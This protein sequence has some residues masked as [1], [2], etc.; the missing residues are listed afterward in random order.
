MKRSTHALIRCAPWAILS[1]AAT[2]PAIADTVVLHPAT[3]AGT[4]SLPGWTVT[5]SSVS[6]TSNDGFD[7]SGSFQGST[8]ALTVEGD[9][10]YRRRVNASVTNGGV[11]S[12]LRVD[13][14]NYIHLAQGDTTTDDLTYAVADITGTISVAGATITSYSLTASASEGMESYWAYAS[15]GGSSSFAFPMIQDSVVQVSGNVSA[16]T[17]GGEKLTL[18]LS[19]Q[20]VN[21]GAAG[22]TLQWDIAPSS[23]GSLTGTFNISGP[24]IVSSHHA[25][26]YLGAISK[27]ANYLPPNGSYTLTG[28]L[29]GTYNTYGFTYFNAPYGWL[30]HPSQ[31]IAV[32]A[33]GIAVR[34]YSTSLALADGEIDV[35]GFY[36]NESVTYAYISAWGLGGSSAWD[37]VDLPSGQYKL[38][39]SA[40]SWIS[41][42]YQVDVVKQTPYTNATFQI[43][44]GTGGWSLAGGDELDLG[45]QDIM[46][47]ETMI[48]FDV[49][50][51][52]GSGTETPI[53]QPR[54]SG[55]APGRSFSA[56]GPTIEDARPVVRIVAS[57]G[58]YSA[59]AYG[60][61]NGSNVNF[62]DFTFTV[63]SPVF[64][65]SGTDVFVQPAPNVTLTFD[66]VNPPGGYTSVTSSPIGPQPPEGFQL[67]HPLAPMYYD[68]T[69]TADFVGEVTDGVKVCFHYNHNGLTPWQEGNLTILHYT[70]GTWVNLVMTIERDL[71]NHWLCAT[72]NS[73]SVFAIMLFLDEDG[74]G[75]W[76][77]D[78]NC[79][80]VA[81]A[82]Q[83]DAD[84][85]D[86]GDVCDNCPVD[87]NPS[88]GDSD[89]NGIGNACDPVC[90]T[91]QR[92]T[93][94]SV[95]DT[96]V[97]VGEPDTASGSYP[98]LYTGQHSSG[99]K[100]SLIAFDLSSVPTDA[101]ISDAT[102]T[103]SMDYAETAGTIHLHAVTASWSEATATYNIVGDAFDVLPNASF[104]APSG[105]GGS[106]SSN[107]VA[108]VQSWIDGSRENYGLV[109]REPGGGQHSF[110][111]SEHVSV[112]QRPKLDL[113][114][115][116]P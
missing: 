44:D 26:A 74:D 96:F 58:V 112:L 20:Q 19:A 57:P 13:R 10:D 27:A 106:L 101:S 23:P 12:T 63:P 62:A 94:G 97:A 18:P 11:S 76:D 50:E 84:G 77:G 15:Q 16:I 46:A 9:H 40:G 67:L 56:S 7:S 47:V 82:D 52:N 22:A 6:A 45:V 25:Y 85:D 114:Y 4:I 29:P 28:L 21:V 66:N 115:V 30:R 104:T 75:T 68:I 59:S 17:A 90:L 89:G 79:P 36:S 53:K 39:L 88:Q 72:T 61:V 55:S 73:F 51:P 54:V 5:S 31:N 65:P 98:Y 86:F 107:I 100:R 60:Y 110:R 64:T 80:T 33:G 99:E 69:T 42:T 43:A 38:A 14:N 8:F 71:L 105:A 3:L 48:V 2:T 35:S 103:L 24:S 108:L 37:S 93:S 78:D 32:P 41:R 1:L 116:T 111:S 102:L 92:G 70:G 34:D 95:S 81:N 49:A 113:C 83:S 91:I 109:L 87:P